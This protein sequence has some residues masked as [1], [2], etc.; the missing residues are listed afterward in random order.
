MSI[1]EVMIAV[2]VLSFGILTA[3]AMYSSSALLRSRSGGYSRA[4]AIAT[5]KLEQIR[6]LPAAQITADTLRSQGMADAA[7]TTTTTTTTSTTGTTSGT[8][9]ST[10]SG[11]LTFTAV[12]NVA[13]DLALG[14]GTIQL[15]G[16]GTDLV[17]I[18][19][20]LNW[21]GMRGK[22]ES[23]STTTYVAD[24]TAWKG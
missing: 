21:T 8:S 9:S 24:K 7:T 22:A 13:S 5:R 14:T 20:T 11:S 3:G 17:G 23:L 15:S 10:S 2:L 1:L 18:T 6:R 4:A 19:V 16:V 12:D